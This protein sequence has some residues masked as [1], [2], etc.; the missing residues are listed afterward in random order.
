MR[1]K[2]ISAVKET[3]FGTYYW[4][5]ANNRP[6]VNTEGQNLCVQSYRHDKTKLEA[7][8]RTAAHYGIEGGRA[9]F[10]EG[11][12]PVSDDEYNQQQQRLEAGLEPD[13][14]NIVNAKQLAKQLGYK[15]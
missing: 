10:Q 8:K 3:D 7:L 12:R 5:D 9:I 1:L 2:N 6:V 13:P 14:L 4:V 11:A 15:F